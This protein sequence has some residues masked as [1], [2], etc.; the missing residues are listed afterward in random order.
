MVTAS[1]LQ[2]STCSSVDVLDLSSETQ[3][4]DTGC[5]SMDWVPVE[6]NF[7]IEVKA[8]TAA[9]AMAVSVSISSAIVRHNRC[10]VLTRVVDER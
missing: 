5:T 2:I 4:F 8:T 9:T 6:P 3:V 10:L 1:S 7:T